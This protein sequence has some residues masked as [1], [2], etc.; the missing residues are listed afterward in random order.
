M[1]WRLFEQAVA[2]FLDKDKQDCG[3]SGV[4]KFR[5]WWEVLNK[6]LYEGHSEDIA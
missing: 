5:V 4:E 1:D 2:H 3:F 6:L